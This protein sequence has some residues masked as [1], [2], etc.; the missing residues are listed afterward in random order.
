[1]SSA[2]KSVDGPFPVLQVALDFIDIERALT[3]ARETVLG[4]ADWLEAGTPLIKSEGLEA[5]RQLRSAFPNQVIVAD[6][7]T[8]DVGRIEFEA[9]AKAGAN[10][11]VVLAAAA[12]S[13]IAECVEAGR[14]YGIKTYCDTIN[15]PFDNLAARGREIAKL[16]VDIIGVHLPIDEQMRGHDPLAR[17]IVLKEAVEIPIAV[18]GGVT[19][20]TAAAM[21]AA[22]AAIVIVGGALHK[23]SNAQQA[24]QDIKKAMQSGKA[25]VSELG[26]RA[27]ASGIAESLL[28]TST[29]N[30]SD[31]MH[32]KPCLRGIVTRTPGLRMAGPALTVRSIAGDWNKVVQAIDV[33]KPGDVLVVDCGG[34]PPAVFGE[35]AAQSAKQ[36]QLAGVVVFGAIRDS[37]V[38]TKIGLPIF[39]SGVSSDAGDP[40]GYGEI[41]PEIEINGQ[42]VKPGDWIF[43]D[44]DGVMVL[45]REIAVEYANRAVDVWENEQRIAAE[46]A[47]GKTLSEVV[48]LKKW[49]KH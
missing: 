45:P 20:E 8:M 10:V 39:A 29:S 31:A 16:G 44:D 18:A 2:P 30:L 15:I 17:L 23:A 34:K 47:S 13:T 38:S 40:K 4:G 6:L 35:L 14:K 49:E 32:H 41:G 12:D 33:A 42:T 24:A 1:M 25:V 46:I 7:K 48:N 28:K 43:G 26:K 21:V 3:L 27:D 22:G 5:I 11:A 36:R 37:D 9:A 19:S